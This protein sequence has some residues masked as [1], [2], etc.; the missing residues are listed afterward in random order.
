MTT[1]EKSSE[2]GCSPVA[3]TIANGVLYVVIYKKRQ[4]I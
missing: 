3:D 1:Y 2:F 4:T